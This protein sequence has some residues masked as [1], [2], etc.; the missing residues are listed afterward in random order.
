MAAPTLHGLDRAEAGLVALLLALA[1]A[2]WVLTE[3]RMGGMAAGPGGE[4]GDVGWFAVSWLL[5]MAA[6]MLPA[7]SPMAVA[8]GRR[9]APAGGAAAFAAGYL[10][11]WLAAGLLA[12]AA[13]EGVRSLELGVLA[14]V[15]A[16]RLVTAAVIAGAGLY[17]LT[18]PK[19]ACLRRCRDRHTF[20]GERWRPGRIGAL[21]DGRGARRGLHRLLL[22][23]D[24]RAAGPRRDEPDVDGG[25][26]GPHHRR[27]PAALGRWRPPRCRG[28]AR[29]AR[30]RC[31]AGARRGA[32]LR[33]P[34]PRWRCGRGSARPART[35][36]RPPSVWLRSEPHA[37]LSGSLDEGYGRTGP[38]RLPERRARFTHRADAARR[39]ADRRAL[40]ASDAAHPPRDGS[41]REVVTGFCRSLSEA[42]ARRRAPPRAGHG[43]AG[44]CTTA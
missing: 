5:M 29:R 40:R 19:D 27:A 21:A 26:G 13:I 39:F 12:Y 32:R 30:R 43:R 34:G 28:R 41:A 1:T 8:Y 22:G 3:R 37:E 44:G 31:R 35:G 36:R 23:A 14:W 10:A 18:R 20:L 25:R 17:Q 4:L 2:A 15:E 42:T 33:C 11:A 24:G 9:P 16:G 7:I 6:M 38:P